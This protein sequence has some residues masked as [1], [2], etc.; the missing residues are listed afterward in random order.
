[1]SRINVSTREKRFPVTPSL[2]GIFFEDINRS[3]DGG[4]YP[5]MLRDRSFED[6]ILPEGCVTNDGGKTMVSPTGWITSFNGGEGL[7]S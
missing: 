5:E 2:Y 3:G 1:M 6:A 7:N 4:L